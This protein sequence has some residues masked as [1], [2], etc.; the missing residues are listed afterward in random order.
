MAV[1]ASVNAISSRVGRRLREARESAGLTQQQVAERAGIDPAN[2]S[3]IENGRLGL[4]L[5]TADALAEAVG[6]TLARLVADPTDP[7]PTPPEP[8]GPTDP[9]TAD[10]I[11]VASRLS[12]GR[13]RL[14]VTLARA[15][16]QEERAP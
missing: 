7:G 12:P 5:A 11:A 14:L 6:W 10:L 1:R 4:A 13:R 2:L 8:A 3:R 16:A 9:I 15:L